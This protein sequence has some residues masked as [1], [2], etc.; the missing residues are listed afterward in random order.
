MLLSRIQV[1]ITTLIFFPLSHPRINLL[2]RSQ[3]RRK[4][5]RIRVLFDLDGDLV[6]EV[7]RGIPPP[8]T[9]AEIEIYTYKPEEEI[10]TSY[11][12]GNVVRTF[13]HILVA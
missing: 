13:L 1:I 4:T 9:L 5:V 3:W 8:P 7:S 10:F 11:I 6:T 12:C 2:I